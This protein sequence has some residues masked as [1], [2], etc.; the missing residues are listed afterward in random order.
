MPSFIA[1]RLPRRYGTNL[2][3]TVW[4]R[5]RDHFAGLRSSRRAKMPAAILAGGG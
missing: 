4:P 3:P 5:R 1:P 2:T